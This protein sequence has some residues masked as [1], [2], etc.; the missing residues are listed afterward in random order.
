A[1]KP[2]PGL[3][4]EPEAPE[5]PSARGPEMVDPEDDDPPAKPSA[6]VITSGALDALQP[7]ERVTL[8][9]PVIHKVHQLDKPEA[10]KKLLDQLASAKGFRLE[11]LCHDAARGLE[12]LRASLTAKKIQVTLDPMAQAR[13]K[14]PLLRSDYA[15]FLENVTAQELMA[16]LRG[17]GVADRKAADKSSAEGRF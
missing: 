2:E 15:V 6:T 12:R 3:A 10:A 4:D 16:V 7:L 13:L 5:W 1:P 11:L 8:A 9:L 14:K 17:A